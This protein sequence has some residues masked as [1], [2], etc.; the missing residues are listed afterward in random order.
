VTE[1]PRA[2]QTLC[3]VST[4][5]TSILCYHNDQNGREQYRNKSAIRLHDCVADCILHD[6][7]AVLRNEQRK[8]EDTLKSEDPKQNDSALQC[9]SE[10]PTLHASDVVPEELQNK[11]TIKFGTLLLEDPAENMTILPEA[12]FVV[13]SPPTFGAL[14]LSAYNEETFVERK[15]HNDMMFVP[16]NEGDFLEIENVMEVEGDHAV[17]LIFHTVFAHTFDL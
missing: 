10:M 11:Y 9:P 6:T 15:K 13:W 5:S 3:C 16:P 14:R 2:P 7:W 8:L 1:H 17:V 4:C 12:D